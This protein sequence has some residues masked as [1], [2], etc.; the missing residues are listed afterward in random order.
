MTR[1][2]PGRRIIATDRA[3]EKIMSPD[4]TRTRAIPAAP[5]DPLRNRGV[6]FTLAGGGGA[7]PDRAPAVRGA[8]PEGAGRAGLA[9]A[10]G[11]GRRPGRE[12]VPGVAARPK[13]G[14]VLPGAGRP[15][16]RA[17][18]RRL[19]PHGRRR[20]RAVL[21][22][23]PAAPGICLSIGPTDGNLSTWWVYLVGP[24]AGAVIEVGVAQVLRGPTRAQ[25]AA[26][27][28]GTPLGRTA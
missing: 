12:R 11:P 7:G 24:M 27:A 22:R 1:V 20:D 9:A 4:M 5:E 19:R 17:A 10:A 23:V 14:A 15:P 18:A 21:G 2:R 28:Q 6:A 25:E 3:R 8:D 26:A 16:G 13:R